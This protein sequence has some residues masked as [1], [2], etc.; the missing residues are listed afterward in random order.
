MRW[1]KRSRVRTNSH[2]WVCM[3]TSPLA[4]EMQQIGYSRLAP[5]F[6]PSTL[7]PPPLPEAAGKL[8]PNDRPWCVCMSTSTYWVAFNRAAHGGK[9]SS[10]K[11]ATIAARAQ[12]A[13]S[14]SIMVAVQDAYRTEVRCC[15]PL[16]LQSIFTGSYTRYVFHPSPGL[17]GFESDRVPREIVVQVC[18]LEVP[19]R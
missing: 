16:S 10:L 6:S 14:C 5:L 19:P 11:W 15:I 1:S 17:H 2:V 9:A 13:L 3:E 4:A 18:V 12:D 7:A 8:P